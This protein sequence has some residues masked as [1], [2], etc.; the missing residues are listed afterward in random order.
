MKRTLRWLLV[1]SVVV[2]AHA[3]IDPQ[4]PAPVR[5]PVFADPLEEVRKAQEVRAVQTQTQVEE[6]RRIRNRHLD[7]SIVWFSDQHPT[8]A[9]A[10]WMATASGPPGTSQYALSKAAAWNTKA[11][12]FSGDTNPD[13]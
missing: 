4:L 7:W 6:R 2:F 11:Y 5:P 1:L 8:T 12:L 10:P 9:G 13:G 3:Q